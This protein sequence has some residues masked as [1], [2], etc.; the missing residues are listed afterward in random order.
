MTTEGTLVIS[1]NTCSITCILFFIP[2]M[3]IFY[4]KEKVLKK[5]I[6][7]GV[8]LKERLNQKYPLIKSEDSPF[9]RTCYKNIN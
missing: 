3:S 2:K 6:H 7:K 9:F 8:N 5:Q 1:R 4:L